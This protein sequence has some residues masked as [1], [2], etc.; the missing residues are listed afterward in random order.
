MTKSMSVFFMD[1]EAVEGI[2]YKGTQVIFWG[3]WKY[4]VL[5]SYTTAKTHQ[6]VH[7]DWI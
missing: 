5:G 2:A 7:F 4:P 3:W 6:I 1:P